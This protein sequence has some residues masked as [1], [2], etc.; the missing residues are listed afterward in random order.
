[1]DLICIIVLHL[2]T[3][4]SN[5]FKIN[6]IDMFLIWNTG[7][8]LLFTRTNTPIPT[9]KYYLNT[10]ITCSYTYSY[11]LLHALVYCTPHWDGLLLVHPPLEEKTWPK[12]IGKACGTGATIAV[13][14]ATMRHVAAWPFFSTPTGRV[15]R[16]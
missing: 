12:A 5:L 7:I 15:S 14:V 10:I 11:Q 8:P 1:M 16:V 4:P 9:N 13:N 6:S 2:G 3:C